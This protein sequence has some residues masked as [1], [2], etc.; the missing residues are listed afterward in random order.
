MTKAT[1]R[2]EVSLR[3]VPSRVRILREAV[4]EA[5]LG[6]GLSEGVID[7]VRLCVSEAVTNVVRHA[8]GDG[9]GDVRVTLEPSGVGVVVVVRDFGSGATEHREWPPAEGGFGWRI[10]R[11]LADRCTIT[12]PREGGTQVS[13]SFGTQPALA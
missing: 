10:I 4:A 8:Y 3:A 6:L 12:N 13:M 1:A 9:V 7:D 2:L 5:A 11:T